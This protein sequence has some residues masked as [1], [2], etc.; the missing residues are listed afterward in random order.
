[1]LSVSVICDSVNER[2][3]AQCVVWRRILRWLRLRQKEKEKEKEKERAPGKPLCC[4]AGSG[5]SWIA[6]E[7]R[8]LRSAASVERDPL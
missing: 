5:V 2:E 6:A 7:V 4:A 8:W 1:M 3:L